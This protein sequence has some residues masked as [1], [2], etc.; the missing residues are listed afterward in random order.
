M[1]NQPKQHFQALVGEIVVI[2]DIGHERVGDGGDD[3]GFFFCVFLTTSVSLL[4]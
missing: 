4:F 2:G 1:G 3:E